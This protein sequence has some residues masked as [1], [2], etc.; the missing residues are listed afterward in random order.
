VTIRKQLEKGFTKS[1]VLQ[2][3]NHIGDDPKR[4]EELVSIF[5]QGPYRITQRAAHPLN[6]CAK[7]QPQLL[8]RHLT[9]IVNAASLPN[10]TESIKRNV[11]RLLQ[12]VDIPAKH[13]G[14]VADLCFRLLVTKSEAVAILVF[15]MTVL[16]QIAIKN[17]ELVQEVVA[18][19]EDGLPHAT[20][21]YRSRASKVLKQLKSM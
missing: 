7:R 16:A 21:A 10:A 15:A 13:Q 3:A 5:L 1:H 17:P 19:I 6:E 20:P 8:N 2:I 4:F 12:F 14:R 9:R 11:V 18:L